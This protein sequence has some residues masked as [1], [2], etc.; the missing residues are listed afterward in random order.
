MCT[1]A[2]NCPDLSLLLPLSPLQDE[3]QDL[4][5]IRGLFDKDFH[6]LHALPFPLSGGEFTR[7]KNDTEEVW[8]LS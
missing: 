3:Y 1:S 4:L 2:I 5:L 7:N 8:S 6:P